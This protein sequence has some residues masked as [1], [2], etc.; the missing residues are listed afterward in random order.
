MC[1]HVYIHSILKIQERVW[2]ITLIYIDDLQSLRLTKQRQ[3]TM[4]D[5]TEAVPHSN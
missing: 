2:G 1:V 3:C 4:P 5:D